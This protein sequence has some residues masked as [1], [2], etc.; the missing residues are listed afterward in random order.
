MMIYTI[1]SRATRAEM[2]LEE[3]GRDME[4][5]VELVIVQDERRG[6]REDV[7]SANKRQ[8]KWCCCKYRA[9]YQIHQ[10]LQHLQVS[11]HLLQVNIIDALLQST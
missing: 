11:H 10:H 1:E 3:K 9:S 4:G 5:R 7:D 2:T 6:A 8:L